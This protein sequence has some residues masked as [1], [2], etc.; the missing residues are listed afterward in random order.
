[1]YFVARPQLSKSAEF[2]SMALFGVID[3]IPLSGFMNQITARDDTPFGVI[4]N[5]LARNF[6]G[7]Q[8]VQARS[9][10]GFA[11]LGQEYVPAQYLLNPNCK[12]LIAPPFTSWPL[13]VVLTTRPDRS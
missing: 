8:A 5:I 4:L 11:P 6:F 9:N 2:T 13:T 10:Y 1:V 7:G 3:L 12:A